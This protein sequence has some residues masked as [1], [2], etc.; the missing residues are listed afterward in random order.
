MNN[1]A[2]ARRHA[3]IS[4]RRAAYVQVGLLLSGEAG[5]GQIFGGGAAANGDIDDLAFAEPFIR[6]DDGA[7]QV[8]GHGCVRNRLPDGQST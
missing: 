8:V 2:N 7:L 3:S 4:A 1:D 5:V 6:D